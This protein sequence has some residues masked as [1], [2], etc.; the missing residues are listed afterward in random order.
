MNTFRFLLVFIT[1]FFCGTFA[2]A[3][4]QA[5]E[6]GFPDLL[7]DE[8]L[9]DDEFDEFDEFNNETAF[10]IRDPLE[11]INRFFFEFND[12]LYEW[13]LKPVT[14]G[15]IWLVPRELRVNFGNF[16]FN[17]A[18]PIRLLNSLLQ[19]NFKDAGTVLSR[20]AINSTIGVYGLVDVAALEFDLQP[21]RADF[22][23]TLG[24]WGA[25]G[26]IYFCWPLFG[27]SSI[28]DTVGLVVDA[29]T[30]PI[31]YFHESIALDLAYYTSNKLNT[32]SL[33]PD[34][35]EDLKRFSLDPYI[36]SRQI[37]YEYRQA[38]IEVN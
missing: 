8:F 21:Q 6:T 5:P 11:P 10:R 31:P 34:L 36:A 14:D 3:G 4:D 29:Y 24:K 27:P 9:E 22:G 37:F 15:Y 33:N 13:I 17:L 26:G 32:L 2:L 12:K 35:Y 25:G 28:R 16:Y 30:H 20:F 7:A 18:M 19:A 1:L 23:Q 38:M